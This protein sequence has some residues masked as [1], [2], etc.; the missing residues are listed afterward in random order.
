MSALAALPIGTYRRAKVLT[1]AADSPVPADR[2]DHH[3]ALAGFTLKSLREFTDTLVTQK[4]L[5][6]DREAEY[7]LLTLTDAGRDALREQETVLANPLRS[8]SSA[9]TST[10]LPS[11]PARLHREPRPHPAKRRPARCRRR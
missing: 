3:G 10:L 4:L 7:P 6:I 5:S 11:S 1:G 9:R 2:C 8:A